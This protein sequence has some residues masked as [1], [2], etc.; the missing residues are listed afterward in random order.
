MRSLVLDSEH[1][2][3]TKLLNKCKFKY[4]LS[5]GKIAQTKMPIRVPVT[6]Y[7][8]SKR[9]HAI[10]RDDLNVCFPANVYS[11]VANGMRRNETYMAWA[12]EDP[13]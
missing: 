1:K 6:G 10:D 8:Q 13:A 4:K 11:Y 12:Q 7:M 2:S 5:D 9:N 3:C